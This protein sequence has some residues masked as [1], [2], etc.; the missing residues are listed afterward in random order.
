MQ[1][2]DSFLFCF[3]NS[4][5]VPLQQASILLQPP[6]GFRMTH[7]AA[8]HKLSADLHGLLTAVYALSCNK[9]NIYFYLFM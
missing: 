3:V 9:T 6:T 5:D 2:F 1:S 8:L 4:K 7:N